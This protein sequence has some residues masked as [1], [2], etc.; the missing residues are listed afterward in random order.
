M[1]I[2]TKRIE[3]NFE[4]H[5]LFIKLVDMEQPELK[6]LVGKEY[7]PGML[8]IELSKCGIHM[9]PNDKDAERGGIHLKDKDAEERAIQDIAQ[10]LKVFAFQSIKWNQQAKPDNI[11][12]R[13]RE[14]LDHFK[15][16]F[17]DDE[18]DWKQVMW[19][20]NKVSYIKAKNSDPSFNDEILDGQVT[21][22]MLQLA[23]EGV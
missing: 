3:I 9:L 4:I 23:T 2:K 12:C 1:T 18:T 6:H 5:D 11:I 20:N 13:M 21:H 8:L 10:T 17:E 7:H 14:N 16:F 19:W 15:Q 22:N